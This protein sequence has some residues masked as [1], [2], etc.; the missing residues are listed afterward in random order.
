MTT[1]TQ[2]RPSGGIDLIKDV[3]KPLP[4]QVTLFNA[5][6]EYLRVLYGGARGGGKSYSLRWAAVLFVWRCFVELG[7]KNVRVGIFCETYRDLN[8]R[9]L[10]ETRSSF[11]EW[12]GSYH[13][14]RREFTLS[15]AFGGGVIAFRNLD[16]PSKYKSVQFAAE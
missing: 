11:P 2:Q 6:F 5:M 3:I 13:S 10:V 16:D 9:H 4:K 15:D 7:L 8:D 12:L 14:E 1:R